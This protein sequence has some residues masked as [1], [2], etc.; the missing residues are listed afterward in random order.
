MTKKD[1]KTESK[2]QENDDEADAPFIKC[3]ILAVVA[4]TPV[5]R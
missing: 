3:L 2:I 1:K 4:P 5:S